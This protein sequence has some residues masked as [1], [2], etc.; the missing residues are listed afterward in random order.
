MRVN[1]LADD[2]T[3]A[4]AGA[5]LFAAHC[6]SCHGET[7]EGRG[8]RPGLRTGRVHNATDGELQWLL[9]NGPLA[10]GMPAWSQL[11]EVQRWQLVRFLHELPR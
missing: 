5:E 8:R 10:H 2:G 7:A 9:R 3:A 6:V 4:A 1:P 11:P